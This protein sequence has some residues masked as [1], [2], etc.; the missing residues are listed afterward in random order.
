MPSIN[1]KKY[2]ENEYMRSN[3]M[4]DRAMSPRH[5][6]HGADD[7]QGTSRGAGRK[8]TSTNWRGVLHHM[9]TVHQSVAHP[10]LSG[11]AR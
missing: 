6:T 2:E 5:G 1:G 7:A 4:Q 9:R 11:N 3:A 10:N 8:G